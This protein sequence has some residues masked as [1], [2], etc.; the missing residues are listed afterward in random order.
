[1]VISSFLTMKIQLSLFDQNLLAIAVFWGWGEFAEDLPDF[2][3]GHGCCR[4]WD[5]LKQWVLFLK[6]SLGF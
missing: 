4:G 2:S 3:G 6:R 5:T 1:M